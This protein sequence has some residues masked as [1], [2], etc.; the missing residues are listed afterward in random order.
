[1]RFHLAL[2]LASLTLAPSAHALVLSIDDFSINQGPTTDTSARRA[3]CDLPQFGSAFSRKSNIVNYSLDGIAFTR[4][5]SVD[6]CT[7][8]TRRGSPTGAIS[9]VGNGQLNLSNLATDTSVFAVRY[10]GLDALAASIPT[11]PVVLQLQIQFRIVAAD[12]NVVNFDVL[13]NGNDLGAQSSSGGATGTISYDL[14]SDP[15]LIGGNLDLV[16]SGTPGF[17]VVVSSL[18]LNVVQT[19]EPTVLGLFGIGLLALGA[20]RT[21]RR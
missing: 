6:L 8:N 7:R 14:G 17:D 16:F 2:V 3:S 20:A 1:M 15:S 13:L 19:P 21:R 10:T 18:G 5:L 12:S 11:D 9:S 4:Q